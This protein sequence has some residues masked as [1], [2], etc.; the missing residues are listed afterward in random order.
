V[1][2]RDPR[3]K[4]A[5]LLI[6]LVLVATSH[7]HLPWLA[8]GW[9]LAL[10]IAITAARLPVW[11]LLSRAAL[12]L[13]FSAVF[14]IV[15]WAAGDTERAIALVLKSYL[16]ATAVLIVAGTTPMSVLL[17]GLESAG[18]P[19]FLLMV[20]QFLYRYLFVIVEEAQNMATAAAAR[21]ATVSGMVARR[22]R[23]RAAA[24]ALAV[25]FA[26]SYGR[27]EDVHRAMLARG[28][29]GHFRILRGPSFSS[30]D[31]LFVVVTAAI[32]GIVRLAVERLVV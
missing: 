6:F 19:R 21:G 11:G 32:P 18:V 5:A 30:A 31:T 2:R 7:R 22:E 4:T 8:A 15:S 9:L 25:L 20:T 14:A 16:S 1:H 12:V 23:F 28:F 17:R 26:R 13:P 3:A 27:A 29:D 24:G 10:L